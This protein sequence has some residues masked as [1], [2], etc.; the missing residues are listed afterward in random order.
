MEYKGSLNGA[1]VYDDYAHHPTEVKATLEGAKA[2]CREAG[3]LICVFQPHTY[4]RTAA[5]LEEFSQAFHGADRVYFA[6]IYAARE[7]NHLV[8]GDGERVGVAAYDIGGTISYK[9]HI[10]TCFVE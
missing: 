7:E 2:L 8:H 9:D 3:D 4:S 6:D 5:L 1:A 10:D